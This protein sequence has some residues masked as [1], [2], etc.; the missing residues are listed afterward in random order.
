[1]FVCL[2]ASCNCFILSCKKKEDP[3]PQLQATFPTPSYPQ[4]S[5]ADAV[6]VAVMASVPAPV[7]LPT[8]PGMPASSLEI[9]YGMGIAA[10][11]GN[12]KADNVRLNDTELKF[13]NGVHM[14]QPD[15]SNLTNP[16]NLTGITFTNGVNWKVTNPAIEKSLTNLPG[17]P[18]VTSAKTITKSAGYTITNQSVGN[19]QKILYGIYSADG[20][21]VLKEADGASTQIHF[22]A[23]ELA[24]LGSTEQGIIQANAYAIQD[25]T[26]GGKKV[27]FVRQSSYSLVSVAIN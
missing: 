8:I 10:F 24:E 12:A 26:I 4:P 15:Y 20:K 22:S 13:A 6:L 21:F 19:A 27:Y 17:T 1:M 18:K 7:D 14:W 3:E 25:E 5:D 11:K 16:A 9:Q 2:I 23:S